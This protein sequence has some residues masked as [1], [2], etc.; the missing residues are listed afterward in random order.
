MKKEDIERLNNIDAKDLLA[1]YEQE[2]TVLRKEL[3][4][5]D[6]VIANYQKEFM[7]EGEE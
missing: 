4:M 1:K 5:K 7:K 2:N 3:Y 6:L